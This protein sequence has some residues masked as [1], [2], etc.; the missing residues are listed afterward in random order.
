MKKALLLVAVALAFTLAAAAQET[1]TQTTTTTT[2]TQTKS[3]KAKATGSAYQEQKE[4]AATEAKE[5]TTGKEAKSAKEQ[6]VTGCLAAGTEPDTYKLTRGKKTVTVTG[7]DLSQ[8]VG[9]EIK[10]TGAY[11]KSAGAKKGRMFKAT[12][13]EHLK[14]TCNTMAA[15]NTK[16]K[17]KTKKPATATP[18]SK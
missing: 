3:K 18:P 15:G 1:G 17:A 10:L 4:S 2:K 13:A 5:K 7:M 14:D 11:E 8:H 9:H 16:G 6:A 12:N